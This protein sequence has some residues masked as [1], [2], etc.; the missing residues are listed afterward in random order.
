MKNTHLLFGVLCL[1]L[2]AFIVL[3]FS[4]S[5]IP[6][7]STS[8]GIA[9]HSRVCIYENRWNSELQQYDGQK[10]IECDHNNLTVVGKNTIRD[11]LGAF[12]PSAT[13]GNFTFIGLGN[14]SAVWTVSDA[15]LTLDNLYNITSG[16]GLN[17]SAGNY[18]V[19]TG[20]G[21]WSV[22]KTFTATTNNLK[23]NVTIL[24]NSTE[25]CVLNYSMFAWKTFSDV[26]LQSGDQILVN[27]TIWVS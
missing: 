14:S 18:V 23:T 15:N 26:T 9:Y 2:G 16:A 11:I 3:S 8:Q 1:I 10:L 7:A 24:A 6:T 20:V 4:T 27:W 21:N 19:Q 13:P 25:C 17:M 12:N 5:V 22:Y